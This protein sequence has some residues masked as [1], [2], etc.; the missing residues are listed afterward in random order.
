[1][2]ASSPHPIQSILIS[3]LQL[4]RAIGWTGLTLSPVLLIGFFL[5]T[6]ECPV[7]PSIS[8]FYYTIMGTYFTG[9]LI[10][11]ALFLFFY[12]GPQPIDRLVARL[13]AVCSFIVAFC[14]TTMYCDECIS[15]NFILLQPH[16]VLTFLHYA[17]AVFLFVLLAFFCFF[18]FTR[19]HPQ[20]KPT[21]QKIRRNRFY[22]FCGSLIVFCILFLVA[23][24]N[25]WI[26]DFL[27]P[28]NFFPITL[29]GE[30]VALSAF[31]VSWLIKGA[32]FMRDH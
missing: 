6:P 18:L 7:P 29:C 12:S 22:R 15:C 27:Q 24:E 3:Y 30:T 25:K 2:S 14:P 10:A 32:V 26:P 11:I 4:R 5:C 20:Q 16:P 19:T 21:P 31:G 13:S 17:A 28:G 23:A 9:T 1:M 8:H